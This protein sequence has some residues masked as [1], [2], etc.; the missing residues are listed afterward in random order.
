MK[1]VRRP[2]KQLPL[3]HYT[4]NLILWNRQ[5]ALATRTPVIPERVDGHEPIDQYTECPQCEGEGILNKGAGQYANI[6]PLCAGNTAIGVDPYETNAY[7]GTR[8]KVAV[9]AAR[10]AQGLPMHNENDITVGVP[11]VHEIME[12]T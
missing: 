4:S 6:C 5:H 11:S 3:E 2:P 7:P 12:L 1:N 10:Y 8:E 9:L